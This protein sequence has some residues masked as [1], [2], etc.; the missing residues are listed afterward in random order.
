MTDVVPY[1][2]ADLYR[3]ASVTLFHLSKVLGWWW[4][5]GITAD[6]LEFWAI[7]V[8]IWISG[9][10]KYTICELLI[11][12]T[13]RCIS[14]NDEWFD[15]WWCFSISLMYLLIV[16]CWW[17]LLV[18]RC[19]RLYVWAGKRWPVVST[20]SD[21]LRPSLPEILVYMSANCRVSR[22]TPMVDQ[23]INI[24]CNVTVAFSLIIDRCILQ[25]QT[26]INNNSNI[27]MCIF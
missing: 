27:F 3:Q 16:I 18:E 24:I 10:I 25:R 12:K 9:N 26:L 15:E 23:M 21:W 4:E 5:N 14:Y 11:W 8:Q 20:R 6:A 2:T 13:V 7:S 1:A 19:Y 22:H 17:C